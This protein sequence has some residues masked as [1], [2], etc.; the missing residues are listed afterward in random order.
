MPAKNFAQLPDFR[1]IPTGKL[2]L[3]ARNP[4]RPRVAKAAIA[5]LMRRKAL[6]RSIRRAEGGAG[7]SPR[8]RPPGVLRRWAPGAE[9][10]AEGGE[11]GGEDGGEELSGLSDIAGM[12][13]TWRGVLLAFGLG[14]ILS[15]AR[16]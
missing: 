4:F 15:G 14:V 1:Q 9:G 5:E 11:E 10:G 2:Q 12:G 6:I 8:A 16:K 13:F 7:A 3:M